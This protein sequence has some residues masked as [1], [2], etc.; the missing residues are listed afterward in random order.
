MAQWVGILVAVVEDPG[1][2]AHSHPSIQ[3][4][5]TQRPPLPVPEYTFDAQIHDVKNSQITLKKV[6]SAVQIRLLLMC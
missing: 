6:E 5:G 2:V 4:Q 1:S 3:F